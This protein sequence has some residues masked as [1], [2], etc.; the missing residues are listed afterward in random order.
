MAK[1]VSNGIQ[2]ENYVRLQ[3]PSQS[4]NE[5]FA[6][7]A[8]ASFV[9]QLDPTLEELTELKTAVSEAVTNAIIHG[10]ENSYGEVRIE[11]AIFDNTVEIVIEDDGIGIPDIDQARQPLFTSRPELERSGM[12]MTIMET[13]VDEMMVQSQPGSG[14]RVTLIKT[15]GGNLNRH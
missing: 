8:V 13:F 6:R 11:C 15:I 7:V 3:F 9:T 10:Y 1:R 12:G 5:S 14:T 4:M 2:V